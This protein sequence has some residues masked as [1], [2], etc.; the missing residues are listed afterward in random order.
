MLILRYF[1]TSYTA[2][3]SRSI[4]NVT[5]KISQDFPR[6]LGV[7]LDFPYFSGISHAFPGFLRLIG[8]LSPLC[9][10]SSLFLCSNGTPQSCPMLTWQ[11]P[12]G[13][14]HKV[15]T[16]PGGGEGSSKR[17]WKSTGEGGVWP[18]STYAFVTFIISN[19]QINTIGET[20]KFY[21][22]VFITLI[23]K[24]NRNCTDKA[25]LFYLS[26]IVLQ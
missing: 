25:L 5:R 8:G 1:V 12:I 13:A 20:Q 2:K 15:R 3:K 6:F 24:L 22:V 23:L 19:N 17:V 4:V 9:L 11:P 14:I 10:L 18:K 7:S 21:P 16:Q 26:V